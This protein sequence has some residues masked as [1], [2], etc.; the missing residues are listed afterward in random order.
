MSSLFCFEWI[1]L[2]WVCC[3]F[4]SR[5]LSF[6]IHSREGA[7]KSR[8]SLA[9]MTYSWWTHLQHNEALDSDLSRSYLILMPCDEIEQE[10]SKINI[11]GLIFGNLFV[12]RQR[13][14][15]WFRER[16]SALNE[17][18]LS[19]MNESNHKDKPSHQ[20]SDLST[21]VTKNGPS[22]DLPNLTHT[23]W[24]WVELRR[25][26]HQEWTSTWFKFIATVF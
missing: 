6:A 10:C 7:V 3:L 21:Y 19:A 11:F 20:Q 23:G 18:K 12:M 26:S 5:H 9:L 1:H 22:L 25:I 8:P 17:S 14:M 24:V 13:L 4:E 16:Y 2:S 15:R